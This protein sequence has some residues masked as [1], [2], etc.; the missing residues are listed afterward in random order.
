MMVMDA[1]V[2]ILK[3]VVATSPRPGNAS[4]KRPGVPNTKLPSEYS[5]GTPAMSSTRCGTWAP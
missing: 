4:E 2:E 5:T 1:M 3:R